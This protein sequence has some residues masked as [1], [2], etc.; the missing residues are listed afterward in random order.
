M[1]SRLTADINC[2]KNA[3]SVVVRLSTIPGSA[4]SSSGTASSNPCTNP[5]SSSMPALISA[6]TPVMIA[7]TMPSNAF[8]ASRSSS[9]IAL[10][11]PAARDRTA[12]T[13][14]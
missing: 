8:V 7:L 14:A 3:A 13:P 2:G 11:S 1:T 4:A 9:G 12:C 6:G 5:F 10:V